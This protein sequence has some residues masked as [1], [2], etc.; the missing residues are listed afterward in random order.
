MSR[1]T[2]QT[3][4]AETPSVATSAETPTVAVDVYQLLKWGWGNQDL[5]GQAAFKVGGKLVSSLN[6]LSLL[7]KALAAAVGTSAS[8]VGTAN[9]TKGDR[10]VA[11]GAAPAVEGRKAALRRVLFL[12]G[13]TKRTGVVP[14]AAVGETGITVQAEADGLD[15]DGDTEMTDEGAD[16]TEVEEIADPKAERIKHLQVSM[17][18]AAKK[19]EFA[20]VARFA[21]QLAEITTGKKASR[22]KASERKRAPQTEF[23]EGDSGARINPIHARQFKKVK[24]QLKKQKAKAQARCDGEDDDDGAY[25]TTDSE[26]GA[27]Y[28]DMQQRAYARLEAR[29]AVNAEFGIDLD[30]AGGATVGALPKKTFQK[31]VQGKLGIAMR[32]V[33]LSNSIG[34][35]I[36]NVAPERQQ[37]LSKDAWARG[38]ETLAVV[39]EGAMHVPQG[40]LD[41]YRNM[42]LGFFDDYKKEHPKG[43]MLYDAKYRAMAQEAFARCHGMPNFAFSQRLFNSVFNGYKCSTCSICGSTNHFE[44]SC[45]QLLGTQGGHSEV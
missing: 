5:P 45:K 36:G 2:R 39:F 43:A 18:A 26:T 29:G 25:S 23:P 14:A 41:T 17:Q 38:W 3:Q 27:L 8:V 42:I 40:H 30:L 28:D 1:R 31:I 13:E 24:R 32:D 11:P 34:H 35:K 10:T 9:T 15:E 22:K 21:E 19:A 7:Q 33:L 12:V 4:P 20:K 44:S 37:A 16:E 6:N